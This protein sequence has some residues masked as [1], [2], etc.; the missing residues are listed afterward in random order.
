MH[1]A[2]WNAGEFR[3][4][5]LFGIGA[6]A[7][8][9]AGPFVAGSAAQQP[10]QKTFP[11]A[12]EASRALFAAAQ[13]NDE[14]AMLEILGPGGKRIVSSGDD[15]EDAQ[16]RATFVE[17]YLQVHRM[18]KE[19][20]GETTLYVGAENWPLPIPLMNKGHVWYFDTAEAKREIVYRRVG[21]NEIS[22]IGVCQQLVA[23]QKEY[24]STRN[25]Y[26]RNIFSDE[27]QQNG[28]Y[29]KAADG[30]P[31]SPIGP[32]VASAVSEGYTP[33]AAGGAPSTPYRGY[34]FRVLPRQGAGTAGG[35]KEYVAG[36]KMTQG[37]AFI[38]YPAEYKSSGVMT[39]VVGQDG[40]VYRKDLGPN[41][42]A[43]AKAMKSYSP[44][45]TWKKDE[46]QQEQTAA[47]EGA[48]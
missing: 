38:A 17:R 33:P 44:D 20:N 42:V 14:K 12:Q 18:M 7:L 39:F 40:V 21:R 30:Q 11:S 4:A 23:A 27:G 26:A 9:L 48:N 8:L 19:P 16:D 24:Y 28:L 1:Q 13:N 43:L 45:A 41:T 5:N 31:L 29:W 36:G 47:A 32:L 35:A 10:G 2:T 46:D 6:L 37:F 22:T 15:T 25:E 34:F 3:C